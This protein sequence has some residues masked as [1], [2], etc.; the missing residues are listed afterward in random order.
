MGCCSAKTVAKDSKDD[1]G[2]ALSSKAGAAGLMD[3]VPVNDSYSGGL[4]FFIIDPQVDFHEGGNLAVTGAAEDSRKIA[5]LIRKHGEKIERIVVSLDTHHAMHIHHQYFW[6]GKEGE[7]P[8]PFTPITKDDIVNQTWTPRQPE[9]KAWA[10]EY[11]DK[12]NSGGKFQM[13]I[14]PDHCLLGTKGHSVHPPLM[15]ALNEWAVRKMRAINWYFKGQNNRAEMY[16]ALK[17]EVEVPDDRTTSLDYDLITTLAKHEKV[18]CCGEAMSHCVNWSTRDLLGGWDKKRVGDI[19]LLEDCASAVTGFEEIANTFV[20]DMR[21]AGVTVSNASDFKDMIADVAVVDAASNA[22]KPVRK[23]GFASRAGAAGL[24]NGVPIEDTFSGGLALFI[25][26]PQVDFHPG[27]SLAV[28]GANEDS[29]RIAALIRKFK[30]QIERIVVTLDTHHKM[31]MHHADFWTNTEGLKPD[32]FTVLTPEDIGTGKWQARQPELRAWSLEYA[33]KLHA[34]GKLPFII[35]PDHCL[36]GTEG[37]SI[38]PPLMEA[39]NEWAIVR[40]R[41]VNFYFKGQNNRAEMYSALKSEVEVLDDPTT[42]LDAD[43]VK[44]LARHNK[45]LCCGEAKSHCVNYSVRHLLEAWPESRKSDIV[46][47]AD[48]CSAVAGF[49]EVATGFEK[50]MEGAGVTIVNADSFVIDSG[51]DHDAKTSM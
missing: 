35:W 14:W 5:D 27:G 23:K 43:L 48:C 34:G 19:I 22:V 44:T 25:I 42:R 8:S 4:A 17:A 41:S 15:E 33:K 30:D 51:I 26:D 11:V 40:N 47:L 36:L 13:L 20:A 16:S 50:D 31:H 28:E 32:P 1:S 21:E 24:M 3:G 10:L 2:A 49:E 37:H 45:V 12:L 46:L 7:N 18:V 39:L 9:M 38:H 6:V 29:A